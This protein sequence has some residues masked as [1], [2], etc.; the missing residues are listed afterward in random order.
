MLSYLSLKTKPSEERPV[1]LHA[2]FLMATSRVTGHSRDTDIL[3]CT[4]LRSHR[5]YM[6]AH[7]QCV[8]ARANHIC[9][10]CISSCVEVCATTATV[11]VQNHS[12]TT[13]LINAVCVLIVLCC[14]EHPDCFITGAFHVP[15][16]QDLVLLSPTLTPSRWG[17]PVAGPAS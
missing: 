5:F 17:V 4:D 9:I 13:N 8:R 14:V 16:D 6:S 1:F 11:R 15:V 3:Q 10:P 12:V 7:V 2:I